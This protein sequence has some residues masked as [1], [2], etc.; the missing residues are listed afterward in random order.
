MPAAPMTINAIAASLRIGEH[1]QDLILAQNQV[2]LAVDSDVGARVFAEQNPV[3]GLHVD[4]DALAVLEQLSAADRDHFGLLRLLFGAVR[5]DDP[6]SD[7]FLFLQAP[8]QYT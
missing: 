7:G 8:D 6:A 1:S 4:C 3:A 2:F 5:D